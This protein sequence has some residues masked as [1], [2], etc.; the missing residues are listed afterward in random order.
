[1]LA[2]CLFAFM[3]SPSC[4]CCFEA[5]DGCTLCDS[6][7]TPKYLQLDIPSGTIT[8]N[9]CSDC[10]NINGTWILTQDSGDSCLW[11]ASH[12]QCTSG[13]V[14]VSWSGGT[15]VAEAIAFLSG[16]DFVTYHWEYASSI[17]GTDCT[18]LGTLTLDT[19]KSRTGFLSCAGG[20]PAGNDV[21]VSNA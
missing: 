17:S 18:D 10:T 12:G 6:N 7:G 8:N 2:F 1:L 5:G 4:N 9:N 11:E 14:K 15:I 20:G 21:E 16:Y 19:N 3:T 13:T